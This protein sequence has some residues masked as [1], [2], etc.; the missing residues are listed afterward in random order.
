M[1]KLARFL[2][3]AAILCA[4]SG[5]VMAGDLQRPRPGPGDKPTT[6]VVGR[7][8]CKDPRILDMSGGYKFD[9]TTFSLSLVIV[10]DMRGQLITSATLT[11]ADGRTTGPFPMFGSLMAR[12]KGLL[13][14]MIAGGDKPTSC[15][16]HQQAGIDPGPPDSCCTT[17][18]LIVRVAGIQ[19]DE[20]FHVSVAF[21][22][23]GT[24]GYLA[25]EM[26]PVNEL[27]GFIV[28]DAISKPAGQYKWTSQ[29]K[30]T[31]PWGEFTLPA[32]QKNE[33]SYVNFTVGSGD[34][35]PHS[36][37]PRLTFGLTL[38]GKAIGNSLGEL[39]TSTKVGYGV[40]N[41]D[42][43]DIFAAPASK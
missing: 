8:V 10:P 31:L 11:L 6:F 7:V 17:P 5:Y 29:R 4:W 34:Y 27:R 1:M 16:D 28:E 22:W 26:I 21:N 41:V 9:A 2:C 33:R 14:F 25:T 20:N 24:L 19:K 40:L 3:V 39:R 43:D 12:P 30:V 18:T 32:V 35:G 37:M 13:R 42:P 15:S 23:E 38:R 36:P